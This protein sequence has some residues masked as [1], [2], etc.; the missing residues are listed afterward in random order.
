MN[1]EE[2]T[3]EIME[4]MKSFMKKEYQKAEILPELL[5]LQKELVN[6]TFNEEHA[7]RGS[8][9]IWD[10]EKHLEQLNEERG[11]VA[12]AELQAF[13]DKCK[14]FCNLI[15]S[16]FSGRTGEEKT[17]RALDVI[18]GN[19]RIIKNC[20]LQNDAEKTEL[21][22]TVVTPKGI[23]IVEVK[24]TGKD[25][26]IDQN[27]DFYRSGLYMNWDSNIGEKMNVKQKLLREAVESA[28]FEKEIKVESIVVFTNSRIEVNNRYEYVKTCFLGALPHIINNYKG[29]VLYTDEEMDQ[30]EAALEKARCNEAYPMEMDMEQFKRDFATV[31]AILE[32]ASEQPVEDEKKAIC[33][34]DTTAIS[35]KAKSQQNTKVWKIAGGV[36]AVAFVATTTY[37]V[38]RHILKNK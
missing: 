10:V 22:A 23:F 3:R 27:G 12:D 36:A 33:R 25:V 7:E 31:M 34:K 29:T 8:L 19:K 9:R 5:E 30:I 28:G 32:T 16:E 37:M 1:R 18:Y 11:H 35:K 13:E 6:L 26:T 15:K 2:R 20:E 38:A 24:N 21:D 14:F 4:S 17:F